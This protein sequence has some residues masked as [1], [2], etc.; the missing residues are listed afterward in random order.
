MLGIEL[1]ESAE[2]GNP[3][4]F[5]SF[6]ALRAIGVRFAADDVGTGY[7]CLQHLKCC[8]ITTFTI[9]HSF[10]ARLPHDARAQTILRA[11]IPPDPGLAFEAIFRRP[12]HP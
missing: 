6:D 10:G 2:V 7:S 1:P 9:D 12:R 5:A 8:P 3:A 11:L 4:L